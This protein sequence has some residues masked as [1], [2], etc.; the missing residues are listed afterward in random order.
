MLSGWAVARDVVS[1]VDHDFIGS[2]VLGAA[3]YAVPDAG[4]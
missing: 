3:R 2:A 4:F 1:L